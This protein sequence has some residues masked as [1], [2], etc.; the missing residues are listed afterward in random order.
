MRGAYLRSTLLE[1]RERIALNG[2]EHD[3]AR[4]C[5]AGFAQA[6]E[7]P[8]RIDEEQLRIG[9]LQDVLCVIE[10][11]RRENRHDDAS[12]KER[13][14]IADDPVD[15][16]VRDQRNAITLIQ[17]RIANRTR[18]VFRSLQN[19]RRGNTLPLLADPLDKC[20]IALF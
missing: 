10:C 4:Q 13:R 20:I 11:L 16:I 18:D 9:V 17:T 15:A 2:I 3:G 19:A 6:L 8:G 1:C 7:T 5:H 12:R 14:E